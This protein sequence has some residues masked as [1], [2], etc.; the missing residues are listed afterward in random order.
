MTVK[1]IMSR[2]VLITIGSLIFA[3]GINYFA[4][5]NKLAE[6]GVIGIALVLHY[7]LDW[8]TG[9]VTYILNIILIGIGYKFLDKHMMGYT[10]YGV[11]ALSIALWVTEGIGQPV[12]DDTLLAPIYA[13]LFVGAG[14]GITFRSGA[15][16][17]GTQIVSKML[18]QYFGWSMA[19]ATLV[20]DL[21]VIGASVFVIGQ[22]KAMLTLIA[23]Y[24]G[25]KAI[26]FI[27][28]G[29]N[30]RKAVTII[31]DDSELVLEKI[32]E[33]FTRGVTVFNGQGGYTKEKKNVL[34]AVVNFQ[35]TVRLQRLVEEVD[36]EAFV[37]IHD[38][39]GAF[40]GGFK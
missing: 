16:S 11:A 22:K 14:V 31:S 15:T 20:I 1:S 6:G 35:E 38:V 39:R 17:G 36:S 25:A 30:I 21:F 2:I 32:N 8:S 27:V 5:P 7:V 10:L 3:I 34:F 26:D 37:V 12:V 28:D 33:N 19:S 24:V 13:G 4:I 18:N 29:M 23:I 40:G 9:L